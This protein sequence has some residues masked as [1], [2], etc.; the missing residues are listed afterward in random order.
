M[1]VDELNFKA[2]RKDGNKTEEHEVGVVCTIKPIRDGQLVVVICIG[3]PID[4]FV[5]LGR[6][7]PSWD[8]GSPHEPSLSGILVMF[9]FV[10]IL[11]FV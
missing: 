9:S 8:Y 10:I 3:D 4:D 11:I 5:L 1:I 2:F 6:I 7:V